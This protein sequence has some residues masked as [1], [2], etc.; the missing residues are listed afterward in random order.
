[1][2][3]VKKGQKGL[4]LDRACCS[5]RSCRHTPGTPIGPATVVGIAACGRCL[6]HVGCVSPETKCIEC[7]IPVGKL[8]TARL[9]SCLSSTCRSK[10]AG[11][12]A[13]CT[14]RLVSSV[15][16]RLAV[17]HSL[18]Q[19]RLE[20]TIQQYPGFSSLPPILIR[21]VSDKV[22]AS[23]VTSWKYSI[24]GNT[25]CVLSIGFPFGSQLLPTHSPRR[26]FLDSVVLSR[27]V[28]LLTLLA[29]LYLLSSVSIPNPFLF[30]K[31]IRGR[32][33][34]CPRESAGA[35]DVV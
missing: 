26:L 1:M 32:H 28:H 5:E 10:T 33:S 22:V 27:L 31:F 20:S 21:I 2:F 15:E 3:S 13:S 7:H 12:C 25:M 19:S 18:T 34:T 24:S 9:E 8:D 17:H 11:L 23:L 16:S 29:I 4:I 6:F 30:Q 35:V 14:R